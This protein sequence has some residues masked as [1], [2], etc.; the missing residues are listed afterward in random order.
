M[1]NNQASLQTII[2]IQSVGQMGV[3]HNVLGENGDMSQNLQHTRFQREEWNKNWF[4]SE[5][6]HLTAVNQ[7]GSL[8]GD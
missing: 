2:I 1:M 4:S 6:I 5:M 7:S 3:F 8:L